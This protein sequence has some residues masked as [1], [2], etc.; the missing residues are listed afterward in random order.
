MLTLALALTL[1][2][3]DWPIELPIPGDWD[4]NKPIQ[5]RQGKRR[6]QTAQIVGQNV[7]FLAANEAGKV[8]LENTPVKPTALRAICSDDGKRLSLS[9][10]GKTVLQYNYAVVEQPDPLYSRSGY[11]HPVWTPSGKI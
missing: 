8:F 3:Q 10:D 2:G 7:V 5:V 9:V 1:L 4:A 6:P 11:L